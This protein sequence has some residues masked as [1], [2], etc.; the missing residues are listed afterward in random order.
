MTIPSDWGVWK[1]DP[2]VDLGGRYEGGAASIYYTALFGR[3]QFGSPFRSYGAH[4][5]NHILN[6]TSS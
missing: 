3:D 6:G 2:S 5:S 1:L 4:E